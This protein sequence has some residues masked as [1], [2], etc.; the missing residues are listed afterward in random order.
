MFLIGNWWLLMNLTWFAK[1]AGQCCQWSSYPFYRTL[2]SIVSSSTEMLL[3]AS[4]LTLLPL[5]LLSSLFTSAFSTYRCHSQSHK[6]GGQCDSE[7]WIHFDRLVLT[8][9]NVEE[10]LIPL[11]T[12]LGSF[13]AKICGQMKA[14]LI[15]STF[16]FVFFYGCRQWFIQSQS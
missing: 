1:V 4:L 15:Y 11:A 16:V 10:V 2:I 14:G 7:N 12:Q 8:C 13:I 6:E 3:L 9:K 5:F